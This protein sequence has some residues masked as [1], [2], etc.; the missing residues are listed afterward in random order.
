MNELEYKEFSK[1][2]EK[3]QENNLPTQF[4]DDERQTNEF[5]WYNNGDLEIEQDLVYA[6]GEIA[7]TSL[8]YPYTDKHI[9]GNNRKAVKGHNHA[10]SFQEVIIALYNTPES[11]KIEKEDQ[12]YY[13]EQELNYIKNVQKYLLFIGLEDNSPANKTFRFNNKKHQQYINCRRLTL[14]QEE[15]NKIKNKEQNYIILNYLRYDFEPYEALVL[16]KNGDYCLHILIKNRKLIKYE[17]INE[18]YIRNN[19]KSSDKLELNEIEIIEAF[20]I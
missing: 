16:N 2:Y 3:F 5:V 10:H 7:K 1:R 18:E 12:K 15:I 11:F 14:K 4:W 6:L 13:S 19:Y 8:Y 20:N 17:E 9:I